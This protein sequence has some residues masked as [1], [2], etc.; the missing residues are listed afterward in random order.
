MVLLLGYV[1]AL[2]I[3][4]QRVLHAFNGSF[5]QLFVHE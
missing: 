5:I 4:Q 3:G 2:A 1:S